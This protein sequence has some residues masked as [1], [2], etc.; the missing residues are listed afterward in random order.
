MSWHA[1][2]DNSCGTMVWS[3][4][5]LTRLWAD[6]QSEHRNS[7]QSLHQPL[8]ADSSHPPHYDNKDR[9]TWMTKELR[10]RE[11]E[12]EIEVTQKKTDR[13]RH[14]LRH[15]MWMPHYRGT[16]VPN[17][18][19]TVRLTLKTSVLPDKGRHCLKIMFSVISVMGN[20]FL[21]EGHSSWKETKYRG[22]P[23]C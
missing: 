11:R 14:I 18:S 20:N 9:P 17:R 15:W 12:L 16:G 7:P 8:T 1:P 4:V 6:T 13:I 21:Q 23:K 10:E 19:M 3:R 5:S 22:Y 2:A